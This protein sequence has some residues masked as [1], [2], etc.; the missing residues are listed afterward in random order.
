M[1]AI[2]ILLWWVVDY[3][4]AEASIHLI[5]ERDSAVQVSEPHAHVDHAVEEDLVWALAE[6]PRAIHHL[7]EQVKGDLHV[8]VWAPLS[9][10]ACVGGEALGQ[11]PGTRLDALDQRAAREVVGLE[12]TTPHQSEV[13]PG[14]VHLIAA[15]EDIDERVVSDI[16]RPQAHVLHPRVKLL[17]L[18]NHALLR[19][20]F[21]QSVDG[22]FVDM[23]KVTLA[24]FEEKLD[25]LNGFLNLVALD[26][27]VQKDIQ[28]NLSSFVSDDCAFYNFP[29]VQAAN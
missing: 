26:A 28:K 3:V 24:I 17:C 16:C 13:P 7:L 19:T 29:G 27:A 6:L 18:A 10:I 1:S 5:E 25:N 23:E 20:A 14:V 4:A 2:V 21:Y 15:D 12:A 22:N 9:V 11:L 8:R